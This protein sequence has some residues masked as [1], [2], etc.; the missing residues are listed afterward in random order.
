MKDPATGRYREVLRNT[1]T[2]VNSVDL[3]RI[4]LAEGEPGTDSSIDEETRDELE[5]AEAYSEPGGDEIL[6][7]VIGQATDIMH[8][9]LR[10]DGNTDAA[11]SESESGNE[12]DF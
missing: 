5:L 9:Q 4:R 11:D 7:E 3:P 1:V 6:W 2:N 10:G 12:S 8:K